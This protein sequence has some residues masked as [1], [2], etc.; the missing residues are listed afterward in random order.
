MPWNPSDAKEHTKKANTKEKKKKWAKIAN[1]VLENC[2]GKGGDRKECEAKAIRI[3]NS[4]MSEENS[5]EKKTYKVPQSAL[6]VRDSADIQ[7]TDDSTQEISIIGYSGNILKGHFFWG[8]LAIDVN[9]I[10]FDG[11]RFAVLEEHDPHWKVGVANKKPDTKEGRVV[12]NKVRVLSNEKAQEFF[13]NAR[14][15]FPYQSSLRLYPLVMEELADG[16]QTEVNGLTMK[17]PGTVFR[18]SR[19]RE[20]SVCVFG[21]DHNTSISMN[22]S[23]EEIEV[24]LTNDHILDSDKS[25]QGGDTELAMRK[26]ARTPN[27][28]NTETKSWGSVSRNLTDYI[29]GYFKNNPG[30]DRPE[31]AWEDWDDTTQAFKNWTA[32]TT[33]LGNPNADTFEGGV[34]YPV[35]NPRTYK[36]NKN[37][38][39]SAKAYANQDRTSLTSQQKSSL[40]NKANKLLKDEFGV[41]EEDNKNTKGEIPMNLDLATLKKDY[42]E[43]YASLSEEVKDDKDK[44]IEELKTTIKNLEESNDGNETRL[45]ELEKDLALRKE[46]ALKDQ[47]FAEIDKALQQSKVPTRLHEKVKQQIDYGQFVDDNGVLDTTKLTETISAEIKDWEAGLD[48]VQP[49]S[50]VLGLAGAVKGG[51]EE[52][53]LTTQEDEDTVNRI[54]S[55]V[56]SSKE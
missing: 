29:D 8:D 51:E 19:F 26:T 45:K 33:F 6:N 32:G 50:S 25:E 5:M 41:D 4:K 54:L 40:N 15:G 46:K 28:E 55:H 12:F 3:A 10:Q 30:T 11:K 20:V 36:L 43:L 35:V 23:P 24:M 38:V 52:S 39:I 47:A 17:G 42:P 7:L 13:Q 2:L 31:D 49:Q 53:A 34:A 22:D 1:E 9:G 16:Q 14:D 21:F 56:T 37:G 27:Y 18:K 44:T 48:E